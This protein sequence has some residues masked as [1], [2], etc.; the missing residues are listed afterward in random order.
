MFHLQARVLTMCVSF[1]EARAPGTPPDPSCPLIWVRR[2]VPPYASLTVSCSACSSSRD[3]SGSGFNP[4]KQPASSPLALSLLRR[5]LVW[6]RMQRIVG[7]YWQQQRF[8]YKVGKLV[9]FLCLMPFLEDE[10][11]IFLFWGGSFFTSHRKCCYIRWD[12]LTIFMLY[13]NRFYLDVVAV[14]LTLTLL[15]TVKEVKIAYFIQ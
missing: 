2:A 1:A 13:M 4:H 14:Y 10:L 7:L 15:N 12:L 11:Y 3:S 8:G 6:R 5:L 9:L